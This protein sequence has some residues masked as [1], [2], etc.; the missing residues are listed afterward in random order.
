V[1]KIAVIGSRQGVNALDVT[2]AVTAL[3]E[4]HG[5]FILVSGGGPAKSVNAVAEQAALALGLPVISFRPKKLPN[6][7]IDDQYGVE[8]WR[9]HKG[10]GT[11][12]PHHRPTWAKWEGA[13]FYRSLLLID[14]ATDGVLAFQ[15][16]KSRGTEFEIDLARGR[17][18]ILEI[19]ES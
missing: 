10:A 7:G 2:L 17:K 16:N 12:I 11:I 18:R 6:D 14:R 8:E 9:L 19:V 4:E 5:E 15:H 13:A 1:K 3:H